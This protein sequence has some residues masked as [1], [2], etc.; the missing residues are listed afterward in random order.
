MLFRSATITQNAKFNFAV[1]PNPKELNGGGWPGGKF[2][3]GFKSSKT[4]DLAAY[5]MHYLADA[6]AMETM[7]KAAFWLPTRKDL[8]AKGITYPSR[9]SDMA[10]YLADTAAT[11][12]AAYGIQSVPT[13]TGLIYNNFRDLMTAVMSGKM[14]A[15]DAVNSQISFIDTQLGT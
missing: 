10:V 15:A 9:Q 8:V 13:L 3:V 14:N 1:V 5:F 11:P 6:A 4:P 7:D 2:L 12:A